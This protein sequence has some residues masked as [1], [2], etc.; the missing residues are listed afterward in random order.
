[1]KAFLATGTA[2]AV[3]SLG[4]ACS[5][6]GPAASAADLPSSPTPSTTTP[7]AS[8]GPADLPQPPSSAKFVRVTS[9][10][11]DGRTVGVAMPLILR[12]GRAVPVARRAAVEE[13][14]T[15]R[16]RPAQPGVWSWTSP[17]EV[18]FRPRHFWLARTAV[19]YRADLAGLPLGNGR[20]VR[21]NLG[22]GISI[23]RAF[24][25]TVDNRTKTM[26][27]E[28]D[29]K[30]V[31]RI[32]VSLGKRSTPSSS[33]TMMVM[34]KQRHAVFDTFD[35]LG[36]D[37]YRT[38]IEYAQRLTWGGEFIHAAPW[39]EDAQ[40]RTNVSHGCVNVSQRMGR[41]LFARTLPGDPVTI[42]GTSRKLRPGNGWTDW[43]D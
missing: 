16:S 29:G 1:M 10:L 41:W 30:V 32:P 37:G 14:L 20:Y 19:T 40:G 39:S 24:V 3:V 2:L 21:N 38:K 33:G 11:G 23:G 31:K 25:M 22:V 4:A 17:T 43:N 34:D 26:T 8:A 12:F 7:A 5:G 35:E 9:F 28:R 18:H 15:V 13:R 36:A 42:R 27:V 6:H